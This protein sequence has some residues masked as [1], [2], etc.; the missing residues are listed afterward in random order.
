MV[1]KIPIVLFV[2]TAFG[3]VLLVSSFALG[4]VMPRWS[5]LQWIGA[6][7]LAG[8]AMLV[9]ELLFHPFKRALLDPDKVSDPLWK[10]G[11]RVLVLI[12][13]F[14]CIVGAAVL[15]QTK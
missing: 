14:S 9:A 15:W 5:P 8:V 2:L 10:R 1:K 7:L 11:F 4:G 13:L 6:A 12:A 3:G